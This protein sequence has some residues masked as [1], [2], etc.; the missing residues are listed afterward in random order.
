M[1]DRLYKSV[2]LWSFYVDLEESIGTFDSAKS[3]YER[4][5][6]LRVIT[7]KILLNYASFLEENK[8]FEDSFRA[9]EKVFHEF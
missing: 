4:M 7:P 1:Q 9:Y 2:K 6:D 5:I 3:A 8:Y